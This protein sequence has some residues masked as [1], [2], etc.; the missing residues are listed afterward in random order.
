MLACGA[1]SVDFRSVYYYDNSLILARLS[2][3]VSDFSCN[4]IDFDIP[5]YGRPSD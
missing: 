4:D 3:W 5:E 1:V 2:Y